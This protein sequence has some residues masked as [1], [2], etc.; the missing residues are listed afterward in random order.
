MTKGLSA[1]AHALILIC[2]LP[3]A[4]QIFAP[5]LI[6]LTPRQTETH[7]QPFWNSSMELHV[8]E[9]LCTGHQQ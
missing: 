4:A 9:E 8:M 3:A 5:P 6:P 2:M 7:G 1:A